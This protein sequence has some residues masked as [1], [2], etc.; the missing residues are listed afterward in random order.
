MTLI[1]IAEFL[2]GTAKNRL[3]LRA[4]IFRNLIGRIDS[5]KP[6]A[7]S[8][9]VIT[10]TQMFQGLLCIDPTSSADLVAKFFNL[11]RVL[12]HHVELDAASIGQIIYSF[13]NI[14]IVDSPGAADII[15]LLTEKIRLCHEELSGQEIGNALYGLKTMNNE[16]LEVGSYNLPLLCHDTSSLFSEIKL[17]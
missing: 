15:I 12:C 17:N 9:S 7:S 2:N 6:S 16:G 8:I 14:S 5:L 4:P 13:Q 1:S 11:L 3:K 10:A